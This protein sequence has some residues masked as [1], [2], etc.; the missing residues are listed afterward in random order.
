[1]ISL[2]GLRPVFLSRSQDR[3]YKGRDSKLI[4]DM[5][6]GI[7]ED[8]MEDSALFFYK[9]LKKTFLRTSRICIYHTMFS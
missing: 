4:F 9:N 7:F 6:A 8:V 3:Y 5:N 1:M 2:R